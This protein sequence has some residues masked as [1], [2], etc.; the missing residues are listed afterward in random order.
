[1]TDKNTITCYNCN[2]IISLESR[3]NN[4]GDCPHCGVELC[5]ED[6]YLTAVDELGVIKDKINNVLFVVNEWHSD[7]ER[8]SDLIKDILNRD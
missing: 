5:M 1:M 8:L 6:Y 2:E 7:A 4:D 3:R